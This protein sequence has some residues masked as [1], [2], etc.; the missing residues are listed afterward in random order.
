V[1]DTA[2]RYTLITCAADAAAHNI[3]I[4]SDEIQ[5]NST[6]LQPWHRVGHRGA[7]REYPANT[8]RSFQRARELGCTM[9]ECD[10]RLSADGEL[11]LAHDAEVADTRGKVWHV[12]ETPADVLTTL[13]LGAGEGVPTLAELVTWCQQ[14]GCAIMADMKCE[15]GT[16]ELRVAAALAPLPPGLKVVPGAGYESRQ[17][18]R[19][20]DP[21]LPLSLSLG[22]DEG[23]RLN[24]SFDNVRLLDAID[25]EAVTWHHHLLNFPI[26]DALKSRGLAVFAWTVDDMPTAEKLLAFGVDGIISNCAAE[27]V[28]LGR[29]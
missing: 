22:A 28:M 13:D 6:I 2:V 10:I 17:R 11:V 21:E 26:V 14:S 5:M 24:L 4:G 27:L 18:F 1:G 19:A 7:P 25:T 8:M 23:E 15:G 29:S 12:S 16:T 20:A 9:V 3:I